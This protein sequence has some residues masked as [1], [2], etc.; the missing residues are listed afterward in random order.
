MR[1]GRKL[2]VDMLNRCAKLGLHLG[3]TRLE[4]Y[5][6]HSTCQNTCQP[7]NAIGSIDFLFPLSFIL[8]RT[9]ATLTMASKVQHAA[10][11]VIVLAWDMVTALYNLV[12]P[13]LKEGHV[14][15]K[16]TTGEGGKWPEYVAPVEG[17]SRSACPALNALAN[18]GEHEAAEVCQPQLTVICRF[19]SP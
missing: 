9:T 13:S 12:T 15:P 18:H 16:G 3:A 19:T 2:Y 14:T 1:I 7:Q 17:D 8:R 11:D 5:D 4:S 6:V 10:Q